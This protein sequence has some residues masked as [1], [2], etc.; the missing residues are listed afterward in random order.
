MARSPEKQ[1]NDLVLFLFRI[2]NHAVLKVT[3]QPKGN[4]KR[5][6]HLKYE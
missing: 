1:T 2:L 5:F 6:I 4:M 3:D